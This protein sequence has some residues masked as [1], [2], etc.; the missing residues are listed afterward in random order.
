M[1]LLDAQ[2]I[3]DIALGSSILGA[4]RLLAQQS[5]GD[6]GP[7]RLVTA[8]EV[9]NEAAIC[10]VAGMGAPGV[11]V[12]KLPRSNEIVAALRALE[13]ATGTQMTHICPVEAGGLNAL[14]PFV[15]AA[16]S[17]LPMLDADGM[18]RA[19]PRL[20][21]VTPTLYGGTSCPMA[22]V[23]EHGNEVILRAASNAWA[24]LIARAAVVASG[25]IT[26]VA[27]NVMSG[28]QAK[29]W[30]VH[31]VLT[32]AE[33]IGALV[34]AQQAGGGDAVAALVAHHRAVVLH[35]GTI[36]A[37]ERRTE[38]G[39]TMGTARSRGADEFTG[40][41]LELDFQNEH[42]VARLDDA[43]V[44]T[45]PDLI[46]V[47]SADSAEPIPAELLHFGQRVVVLAMPCDPHWHSSAG[48]ALAGPRAFGYDI[49]FRPVAGISAAGRPNERGLPDV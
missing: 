41:D 44:A 4:G 29:R 31:G 48:L 37:V 27:C 20:D 18:G 30:L 49:D 9:H 11:L 1:R 43:I 2:A 3:T 28:T 8:A 7:V 42:L 13:R 14:I 38:A 26:M 45:V 12:E 19:F 32:L 46:M 16:E 35:R 25:C 15:A 36:R 6:R 34:R 23:D 5:V 17:G 10:F 22:M 24:E 47:L 33:Q 39:W 40:T 21:L